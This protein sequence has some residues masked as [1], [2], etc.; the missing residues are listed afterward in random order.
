MRLLAFTFHVLFVSS[1]L[2][3]TK[4]LV[5][6]DDVHDPL[7]L[8][9]HKLFSEKSY[10]IIHQIFDSLVEFSPDG[11]IQPELATSWKRL[12]PTVMQF[13]LR[14]GVLFHNGE[15]FNAKAA[16]FTLDR[17]LDPKTAFPGIGFFNT[18]KEIE[19]VDNHTINIHTYHPDGIL[20]NRLAGIIFIVP[21]KYYS[22]HDQAVLD[23]NPVG[24]GPFK[25]KAWKKGH[26]IELV[27]NPDYWDPNFPKSEG[28]V[29]KFIPV[30]DQV[31]ALLSG[32]ID[33][34][35]D[36]PG[37]RTIDVQENPNTYVVKKPALYTVA[38]SFNLNSPLLRDI[39]IRKALNYAIDKEALIRYDLLGN[40]RPINSFAFPN[41]P[42]VGKTFP[43]DDY[44]YD[45]EKAK[46][47]L[48]EAG[49]KKIRLRVLQVKAER[50]TKIITAHW[51]R[52]GIESEVISSVD[53]NII[54]DVK[55]QPWDILIGSCPDPM[56]HPFFIHSI[57]LYSK[58]P[59]TISKDDKLDALID[60]MLQELDPIKHQDKVW[61][62]A[63]HVNENALSLFTYQ[64]IQA[65]GVNGDVQFQPYIS[66]MP[67][68]RDTRFTG[69]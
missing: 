37:T 35:T 31:N 27:A 51:K 56:N 57:F 54:K 10:T 68:F 26:S 50:A 15:P 6:C 63:K 58:S 41:Y 46:R 59:F 64:K 44:Q 62:L 14:K 36:L 52:I 39:Q 42:T 9:P 34:L 18:V 49:Y 65:H 23:A 66:G 67:Y 12:E 3:A 47:L 60:Q 69:N 19:I 11:Q 1:L 25:F 61:Q 30:D 32:K 55:S 8:D 16:K 43:L 28:L 38:A 21:P 13:K 5:I 45:P 20:L 53:A 4:P 33:I 40:G 22:Q 2:A 29:F 7:R 24:T 17:Y 48:R